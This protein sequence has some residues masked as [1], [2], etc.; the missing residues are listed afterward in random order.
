ME[1]SINAVF[2]SLKELAKNKSLISYDELIHKANLDSDDVLFVALNKISRVC[3]AKKYPPIT[4]IV[5]R[6]EDLIPG[7]DFWRNQDCRYIA[8]KD[9]WWALRIRD[10][11]LFDWDITKSDISKASVKRIMNL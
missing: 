8:D 11:F 2:A 3:E 7:E 1:D 5:L 6:D 4:A 9:S 10:V